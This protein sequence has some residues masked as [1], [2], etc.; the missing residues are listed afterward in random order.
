MMH[1]LLFTRQSFI[2]IWII[3]NTVGTWYIATPVVVVFI[4]Y[5]HRKLS[6]PRS[7]GNKETLPKE[8]WKILL[9]SYCLI[10]STLTFNQI[11][12]FLFA[13]D[14]HKH[15]YVEWMLNAH[16]CCIFILFCIC[17]LKKASG[18]MYNIVSN[19][20]FFIA[21]RTS[22]FRYLSINTCVL[23]RVDENIV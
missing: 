4:I 1:G 23:A 20:C 15:S 3:F 5:L 2:M 13:A 19:V 21:V 16:F 12:R 11:E 9:I 17:Y 10:Q 18:I 22:I 7:D 14:E 8:E 6:N